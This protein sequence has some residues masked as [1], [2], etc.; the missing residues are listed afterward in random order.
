LRLIRPEQFEAMLAGDHG[1]RNRATLR[2]VALN[3]I[4]IVTGKNSVRHTMR[5]AVLDMR[6]FANILDHM[7]I[8]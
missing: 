2:R 5:D 1:P 3:A 6:V 8:A 7:P 4:R